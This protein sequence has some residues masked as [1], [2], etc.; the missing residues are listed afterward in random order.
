MYGLIRSDAAEQKIII[1]EDGLEK[2][3]Q[4]ATQ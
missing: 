2:I 1:W 3:T 4:N